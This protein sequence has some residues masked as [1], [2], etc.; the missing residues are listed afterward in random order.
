MQAC[1]YQRAQG[2][3]AIAQ[4]AVTVVPVPG[5]A[6]GLGERGR[7]RRDDAAARLVRQP[8]QRGERTVYGLLPAAIVDDV[9]SPVAP[10]T[11]RVGHRLQTVDGQGPLAV[12]GRPGEH[13][14]DALPLGDCKAGDDLAVPLLVRGRGAQP[15]R[16]R[17][18]HGAHLATFYGDPGN[19]VPVVEAS[20]QFARDFYPTL[21]ALDHPHQVGR[22]A[23]GRHAV[24]HAYR[25]LRGLPLGLQDERVGT[26]AAS[27]AAAA[28]GGGDAPA[29]VRLFAQQRGEAGRRVEAGETQP[30]HRAVGA[31]QGRGLQIS[32]HRVV[33]DPARHRHAPACGLRLSARSGLR[34]PLS[35]RSLRSLVGT[36]RL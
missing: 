32:H 6:E 31:D 34:P 26:V 12:G 28:R 15:E 29:A 3:G 11:L 24:D 9:G 21:Y 2:E 35:A 20:I 5:A 33:F 22:D 30:I 18:R 13:E 19:D 8:L 23:A 36:L 14:R 17:P 10:E 25:T 27:G 1:S 4:P 16:V 7:G